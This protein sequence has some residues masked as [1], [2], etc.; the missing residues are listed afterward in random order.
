[1]AAER[2]RRLAVAGLATATLLTLAACAGR[3]ASTSGG[4]AAQA[5]AQT[6]PDVRSVRVVQPKPGTLTA[7]RSAS[8]TVDP[9]RSS[10]VAA[11]TSGRVAKVLHR[12]GSSVN[13]GE[14]LVQLD[15]TALE[16]QVQNAQTGLES[17]KINLTKA[18]KSAS[19]GVAQAQAALAAAQAQL[20]L[21][22]KQVADGQ[23][24]YAAGGISATDLQ[25]LQTQLAQAKSGYQQAQ[26][27]SDKAG[28]ADTE[29]L[30]LLKLQVQQ[31]QIQLEQAQHTLDEASI[32]A[33]F[34]GIV[35]DMRVAE[36]EFVATGSAVF[37]LVS[38]GTQLARFQVPPL[39]AQQ[40]STQGTVHILYG[41]LDYAAQIIRSTEVPG[42]SRLVELTARIYPAKTRIPTGAT[43]QLD[44]QITLGSG[45][46][47]P[48]DAI[49]TNNGQSSVL[50][51]KNGVATQ[52]T[53]QLVAEVGGNA[54]VL[55]LAADASVIDPVPSDLLPG[56]RVQVVGS[57]STQ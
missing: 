57:Q 41:G 20:A 56:A 30:Q 50:L 16:L 40:L 31:A 3:Q 52:T 43:A 4:S 49:L 33:P 23:K 6:T 18:Q 28:R 19:E 24:L 35:A 7:Q 38:S 8:V 11:G 25:N 47:L 46:L 48:S 21:A 12:E 10:M 1:M 55:G 27:A 39:D 17:A 22:Q 13:T 42:A 54:A 34:D 29:D 5:G 14:V 15:T 36:G 45:Q 32:T 9:D 2:W 53:V 37:R 26:A 44:Y 51:V